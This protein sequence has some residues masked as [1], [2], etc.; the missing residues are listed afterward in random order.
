MHPARNF[1]LLA[2][3]IVLLL[4]QFALRAHHPAAL[5]VF[6]DEYNHIKRAMLAYQFDHNPIRQSHGK[7]LL[8]YWL[9]LF[10]PTKLNGLVLSRL[11]IALFSLV[12][13]AAAAAAA[14]DLAGRRA[15]IPALA[16]YAF[17]P[18]AL[19]FD[20]MALADPFAGALAALAV[21]S[22]I[23]LARRP[24]IRRGLICGGLFALATTAK[25][26]TAPTL[27]L[28][29]L[30]AVLFGGPIRTLWTRYR[31]AWMAAGI[32]FAVVWGEISTIGL[33]D[34]I[35]MGHKPI[36]MDTYLV[37][38]DTARQHLLD[39]LAAVLTHADILLSTPLVVILIG[40]AVAL[41]L[42]KPRPA[43]FL[44]SWLL[45]LWIPSALLII[46]V[47]SRY[48]MIG[49]PALAA[50]FGAGI[51]VLGTHVDRLIGRRGLFL[52]QSLAAAGVTVWAVGFALP[53]A[54]D[55]AVN[56]AALTLPSH[57]IHDY[58]AGD[59]NGWGIRESLDTLRVNGQRD[60]GGKIPV[61]AVVQHCG[62]PVLYLG[63]D[64]DWTCYDPWDLPY[65]WPPRVGW[66]WPE[67][68]RLS[69]DRPLVYLITEFGGDMHVARHELGSAVQW[70]RVYTVQRPHGGHTFNMWR[71]STDFSD[72]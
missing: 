69:A 19:F 68:I 1:A 46:T 62:L 11:T 29:P 59:Y 28:I 64:F 3:V 33:L 12:G 70:E 61:I 57:D 52:F 71:I 16:F 43:I 36:L 37:D 26:I 72:N 18:Y 4:A 6:V 9:G 67:I 54:R 47:Q 8:Y 65:S 56:P 13:S 49:I 48:L 66:P 14:R 7:L 32:V 38:S 63:T 53:F 2:A 40:L 55:A 24:T 5:P 25:L 60:A 17:A 10:G 27:A 23:H 30:A 21:W 34:R 39:K 22:C 51:A 35:V 50:I 15:M 44:L 20:R 58:F 42:L 45:L 31:R 41:L